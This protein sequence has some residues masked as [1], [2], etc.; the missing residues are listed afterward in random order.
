MTA[1][2]VAIPTYWTHPGGAGPEEI[3]FDH[4]TPL[5]TPGTLRRTLE[6]LIPLAAGL[7]V[8][9]TPLAGVVRDGVDGFVVPVGDPQAIAAKL[10]QLA[11]DRELLQWMSNNARQRAQEFSLEKYG[12]RLIGCIRQG[13]FEKIGASS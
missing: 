5:D 3:V 4:P 2:W 7:P 12:E 9:V 13:Y 6:S 8:I 10:D 1:Y 11:R